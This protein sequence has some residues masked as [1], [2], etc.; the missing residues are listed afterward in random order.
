MGSFR[1]QPFEEFWVSAGFAEALEEGESIDLLS[2]SVLCF[3]KD[4]NEMV[5]TDS[6][7]DSG[8]VLGAD[9]TSGFKV[10]V[11]GGDPDLSPYK[12]SFRAVTSSGN[13]FEIDNDFE[14]EDL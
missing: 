3:D 11:I 4:G 13:K 9:G 2:S 14:V 1:K 6:L 5:G 8:A 10:R 7:V 12:L